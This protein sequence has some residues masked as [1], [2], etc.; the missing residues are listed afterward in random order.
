MVKTNLDKKVCA[1]I[2]DLSNPKRETTFSKT[3]FMI[4]MHLMYKKRQDANLE[5]P[6]SVPVELRLSA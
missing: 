1:K 4:A 6:D 5:L 3:M 2:W